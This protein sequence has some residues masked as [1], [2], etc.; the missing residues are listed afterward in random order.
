M[1]R[2]FLAN[3]G[4]E[5]DAIDQIMAENQIVKVTNSMMANIVSSAWVGAA[6]Y[7]GRPWT[8]NFKRS[9]KML[10]T[11]MRVLIARYSVQRVSRYLAHELGVAYKEVE[12]TVLTETARVKTEEDVKTQ[13][14]TG[15]SGVRWA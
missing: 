14:L 10:D 11:L 15:Q 1:K 8:Q 13:A 5:K 9:Q 7:Q 2:E 12:L 3:L 6:N 4:L